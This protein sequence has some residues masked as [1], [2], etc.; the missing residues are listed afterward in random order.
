VEGYDVLEDVLLLPNSTEHR[1]NRLRLSN[2]SQVA[3]S[4]CERKQHERVRDDEIKVKR[5][6]FLKMMRR[7]EK[8]REST[9]LFRIERMAV[10]KRYT[11]ARRTIEHNNVTKSQS[12]NK[13][14]HNKIVNL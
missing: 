2:K 8:R 13:R 5:H 9:R 1:N 6:F 3:S 4:Y 14:R 11:E 10:T 7:E 12:N